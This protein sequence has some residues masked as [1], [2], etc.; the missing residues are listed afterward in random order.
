MRV[1]IV[2]P[3]IFMHR[4]ILPRVIFSPAELAI[5]LAE[6]LAKLGVDVEL[7]TPGPVDTTVRN[8]TADLMLFEQELAGRGYDFTTLLKKHPNIFIALARQ[9]QSELLADVYSRANAG[10]FDI[11]HVYTNEEEIGLAFARLCNVPVVFTH[12]DP[13]NFLI[14]YKSTMP[15]YA[16]LPWISLS[17]AQRETMPKNTNWVANIYHGLTSD[18]FTPVVKPSGGYVAYLGR[19]IEPKGVHFAIAAVKLYNK[20]HTDTLQLRIAGKHYTDHAKDAYWTEKIEPEIDGK[21][22]IYDGFLATPSEKQDFLGNAEALLV[23]SI[24]AEPFGMV[25][26]EALACGTPVIGLDSGAIP[27]VLANPAIG[28]VVQKI[29]TA[30]GMLD[31]EKTAAALARAMAERGSLN[32][33]QCRQEFENRF[34]VERMCSD[35]I[36]GYKQLIK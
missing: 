3:H 32:R 34:T 17:Y 33:K 10:E 2:V 12:H 6:G 21:E 25:S 5:S 8:S 30:E 7:C 27:E 9:V 29:N 23:P 35:H 31:D 1:A 26:I 16:D 11:V 19:I 4:D 28:T 14:K 15:K 22:I 20:Q 18:V 24:F 13:F 36:A